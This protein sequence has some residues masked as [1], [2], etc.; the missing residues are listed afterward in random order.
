MPIYEYGCQNCGK[1]LEARQKISDE[2]LK[3][4]PACSEDGLHRLISESSFALKGSGWYADGYGPS[5]KKIETATPAAA[6]TPA[7]STAASNDSAPAKAEPAPKAAAAT[8]K[9]KAPKA[10]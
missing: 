5:G 4:C 8:P 1:T 6:T 10:D 2:P 7:T 3:T 9:S